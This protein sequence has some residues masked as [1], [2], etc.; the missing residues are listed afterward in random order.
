LVGELFGIA[1]V[2]VLGEAMPGDG[3]LTVEEVR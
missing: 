1:L 3:D 2:S